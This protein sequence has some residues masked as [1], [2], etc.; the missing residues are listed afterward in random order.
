VLTSEK[1][2]KIKDMKKKDNIPR[3]EIPDQVRND[4]GYGRAN[5]G[6]GY[7]TYI[8]DSSLYAR[9]DGHSNATCIGDSSLCARND[10]SSNATDKEGHEGNAR[11]NFIHN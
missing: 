9:N 8:G 11:A 10:D 2:E 3:P 7:Y 4:E 6:K 5:Y 1:K